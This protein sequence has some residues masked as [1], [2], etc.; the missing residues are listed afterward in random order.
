MVSEP[1]IEKVDAGGHRRVRRE[2]VVDACGFERLLES[3]LLTLDEESNALDGE[4]GRVPLVHVED[5]GLV[6][7]GFERAHA[8]DAEHDF[9]PDARVVVAA[10]ELARDGAVFLALVERGVGVE[11]QQLDAADLHHPDA[12]GDRAGRQ[13]DVDDLLFSVGAVSRPDR[14]SVEIVFQIAF[15]L[16]AVGVEQLAEV[17]ELVEKTDADEREIEIAR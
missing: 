9:L 10:V 1:G 2:D 13:V 14:Q 17:A 16:P 8:A 4:K 11:Q 6:A 5:G 15:L 12:N 3:Q 7:K